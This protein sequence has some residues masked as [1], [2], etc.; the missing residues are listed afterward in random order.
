MKGPVYKISPNSSESH[1]TSASWLI[2]FVRN[3]K[4]SS[5][6]NT[7]KN[8]T[9]RGAY[10]EDFLLVKNDCVSIN[11]SNSK[12]S[13]SKNCSLGMK[14]TNINYQNVIVPGDWVFVWICNDN[15]KINEIYNILSKYE[16]EKFSSLSDVKYG[17]K[18]FGRVLNVNNSLGS[19][20]SGIKSTVQSINCQSF[21]D[22]MSSVYFA[23]TMYNLSSISGKNEIINFDSFIKEKIFKD[24]TDGFFNSVIRQGKD[25]GGKPLDIITSQFFLF[26][27]A[28]PTDIGG[29]RV[30]Y[31]EPI[32]IPKTVARIFG[33]ESAKQ[34]WETYS[35]ISGIQKY[36]DGSAN[37]NIK[38]MCPSNI[39][40]SLSRTPDKIYYTDTRTIPQHTFN[41]PPLWV[42]ETVWEVLNQFHDNVLNEMFVSLKINPEGKIGPV[43]TVREKPFSTGLINFIEN[44]LIILNNKKT[45]VKSNNKKEIKVEIGNN[46]EIKKYLNKK[47]MY[48]NLPRWELPRSM[49]KSINTYSTES[50]RVNFVQ[51][52]SNNSPMASGESVESQTTSQVAAYNFVWDQEDIGNNG[53]RADISVVNFSFNLNRLTH[54]MYPVYA[55][56]R[57]DWML[58]GHLKLIGSVTCAGIEEP[59]SEGDNIEIDGV[60]YHIESITHACSVSGNGIKSF[61]T[62]LQLSNGLISDYLN[63]TDPP[64]YHAQLGKSSNEIKDVNISF[65]NESEN[66]FVQKKMEDQ[67]SIL[68]NSALSKDKKTK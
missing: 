37:E 29:T 57:A 5:F 61:S 18:F 36:K 34:V 44:G 64:V 48:Y 17:L 58:N 1:Q 26:L 10:D 62:S 25:V 46:E 54:I 66:S 40:K 24:A 53:L 30:S 28:Y 23:Y 22:L 42:N 33:K 41:R 12:N 59:I 68:L 3:G 2:C 45:D 4:I 13:P 7:S 47:T 9:S 63:D 43:F 51:V 8:E 49:I 67:R 15:N 35:L 55:R 32:K 6:I 56:K 50:N 20:A 14:I 39:D 38:L 16:K 31:S 65:E 52:W 19:S 11:I 27:L 21:L 60:L